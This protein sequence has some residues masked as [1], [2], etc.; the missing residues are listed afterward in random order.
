MRSTTRLLIPA[1]MVLV[2]AAVWAQQVWQRNPEEW[3]EK[4]AQKILRDSPWAQS[5]I[6]RYHPFTDAGGQAQSR[7]TVRVGGIPTGMETPVGSGPHE[8][9]PV[10][11]RW[12]SSRTIRRAEQV[13]K[14]K[15]TFR[16]ADRNDKPMAGY[17]VTVVTGTL[18]NPLPYWKGSDLAAGS[19]LRIEPGGRK[20]SPEDVYVERLPG[21]DRAEAYLF[22]FPQKDGGGHA[23]IEPET[24][25]IH[26][27][28][29][30]GPS[31]INAKFEPAKMVAHDGPDI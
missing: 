12:S 17:R 28:C 25:E 14:R 20:Y 22:L 7:E 11:V 10:I 16:H 30:V 15:H 29:S 8:D 18:T 2:A 4:D 6:L 1:G 13:D 21:T 3:K 31:S 5:T 27:Y 26:F 9:W 19:Y 24:R 23:L